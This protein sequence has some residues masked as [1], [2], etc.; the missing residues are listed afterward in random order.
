LLQ[1]DW[2]GQPSLVVAKDAASSR[3]LWQQRR[4]MI[5]CTPQANVSILVKN[6]GLPIVN[7]PG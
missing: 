4:A 7:R 1:G 2:D 6:T 5:D 3:S